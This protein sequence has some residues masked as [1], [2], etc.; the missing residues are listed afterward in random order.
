MKKE[1]ESTPW[2][3]ESHHTQETGSW[4]STA[5]FLVLRLFLAVIALMNGITKFE[6]VGGEY[7]FEAY[8]TNMKQLATQITDDSFMPLWL[9]EF[10]AWPLGFLLILL[11]LAIFM[12]YL[13]E[14]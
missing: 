12:G 10:F 2:P 5:G 9:S 7:S 14:G 4:E 1:P 11:G 8:A 3:K 13:Q 6:G